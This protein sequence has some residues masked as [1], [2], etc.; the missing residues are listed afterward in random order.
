MDDR[1]TPA[2]YAVWTERRK[3]GRFGFILRHGILTR[4]VAFGVF[5]MV[6]QFAYVQVRQLAM[7]PTE[8]IIRFVV[9]AC[10]YGGINGWLDW[11]AEEGRYTEGPESDELEPEIICLKC[12]ATIPANEHR[13]PACGWSFDEAVGANDESASLPPHSD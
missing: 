8:W 10:L 11:S 1:M 3:L 7:S 4:G 13:C 2:E 5:M 9:Y 6:V 12:E